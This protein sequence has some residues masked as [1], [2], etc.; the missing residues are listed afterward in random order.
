MEEEKEMRTSTTRPKS[1]VSFNGEL[2][3]G[4][5]RGITKQIADLKNK[6]RA[7]GTPWKRSVKK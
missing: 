4:D 1:S 2:A 6:F 5:V 7:V 3:N